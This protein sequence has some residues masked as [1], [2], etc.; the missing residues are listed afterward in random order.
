MNVFLAHG[1]TTWLLAGIV[2]FFG[3][4]IFLWRLKRGKLG[5]VVLSLCVWV[6]AY[7]IHGGSTNG[8]MTATVIA[9]LFDLI[10][11]PVLKMAMRK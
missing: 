3:L 10:G 5:S 1:D 2:G 6:F 8:V 7:K 4:M 9:L 11:I